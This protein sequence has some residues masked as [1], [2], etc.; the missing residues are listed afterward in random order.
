MTEHTFRSKLMF[1]TV[2][3]ALTWTVI[4]AASLAWNI[5]RARKNSLEW[6]MVEAK[7]AFEKD[8]VY[9]RWNT[10]HGGVYV[11]QTDATP[12]N[13]YLAN[14]PERD[15][16]TES[17]MRL[18][19]INPAY[20]TR[21][22]HELD[23]DQTSGHIT[24]V[25]PL[26]PGNRPDEWERR[27]LRSFEEGESEF[28]SLDSMDDKEYMRL[29]RPLIT[30]EGCLACHASQGYTVGDVRGGLSVAVSMDPLRAIEK[31]NVL[32]LSLAHGLLW[33]LGLLGHAY[34]TGK[35]MESERERRLAVEDTRR[36]AGK[37]EESNRMK[38]LFIDIMRHDLLNPAGVIKVYVSYLAD[39]ETDPRRLSMVEKIGLVNNK[40]IEMIENAS[41]FSH[42]EEMTC[43]ECSRQDLGRIVK[44]ALSLTMPHDGEAE[45][46]VVCPPGREYPA[47]VNPMIGD[48]FSNIASNAVKYAAEGGRIEVG[49][50]DEGDSWRV[51]L[52]DFG[53]GVPDSDKEK[54]FTR[55]QRLEKESIKG[56]GL[57][58][59]IAWRLVKLHRG[60]IWVEDN[61]EGG[62]I[63]FVSLPK[64]DDPGEGVPAP[65]SIA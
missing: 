22:V 35:L 23:G 19:L 58:L 14:V 50:L 3:V 16:T 33:L 6:A 32:T 47:D 17:G 20:M 56:T 61:P 41:K 21:Q 63:F 4:V 2:A 25:N 57:G 52:K 34:G 27:A 59:A 49:I 5:A 24:S 42:L 13:P 54:I 1:F 15:V 37:L 45:I 31:R 7:V 48:V 8:L 55:F 43:I 60:R 62:S 65:P 11:R 18:T 28:V 64:S 46:E 44:E 51:Y 36:Y 10:M 40:L 39:G 30:E 29:M 9:R 53:P 26:R 38:D 12:P